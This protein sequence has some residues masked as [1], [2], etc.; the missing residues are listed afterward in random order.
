MQLTDARIKALKPRQ[1]RYMVSDGDGLSLDVLPSGKMSWSF[2]YRINGKQEK[3]V[4]GRYPDMSLKAARAARLTHAASVVAG[5]S[6]AQMKK[7]ARAGLETNPTVRQFGERYYEEQV[8][9]RW[10]DPKAIRRYL[11]KE[12]YPFLGSKLLKEL[13][14]QD[15]QAVV[16]RK[17]DNGRVA[18]AI[19]G[20]ECSSGGQIMCRAL[21]MSR[22]SSLGAL[23]LDHW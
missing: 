21:S 6:P 4:L 8:A 12:I 1:K 15:V 2:R 5:D 13:T 11:D 7:L 14:A 3:M 23:L 18:A 16:Y 20:R 10:K 9:P 19:N 17:R 22:K